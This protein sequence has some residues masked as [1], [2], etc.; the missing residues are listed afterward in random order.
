HPGGGGGTAGERR[1]GAFAGAVR[2]EAAQPRDGRRARAAALPLAAWVVGARSSGRG[3]RVLLGYRLGGDA[4][5]V[6]AD[7]ARG[8]AAVDHVAAAE[9]LLEVL[10]EPGGAALARGASR[11]PARQGG[12]DGGAG[13][14]MRG[15]ARAGPAPPRRRGGS[16]RRAQ[17]PSRGA[18][19][20]PAAPD[21]GVIACALAV[22]R[23]VLAARRAAGVGGAGARPR[24]AAAQ[25]ARRLQ[26]WL[27]AVPGGPDPHICARADAVLDALG[28]T[29]DA[30]TEAGLR[31]ALARHSQA[32]PAGDG[33]G[34]AA[35][36]LAL[37]EALEGVVGLP[38]GS[39]PADARPEA[40]TAEARHRSARTGT[41]SASPVLIGILEFAGAGR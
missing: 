21:A 9:L 22:A 16:T 4:V 10:R 14:R 37:I 30:G 20:P 2:A 31:E 15:P 1:A 24:S 18:P 8:T 13:G 25:A 35:Q 28:R 29:L 6:V 41:A 17:G 33:G 27:A 26:A 32:A 36:A 40:G 5:W 23:P 11:E 19:D 39:A 3:S 34:A 7:P 38:S 12:G